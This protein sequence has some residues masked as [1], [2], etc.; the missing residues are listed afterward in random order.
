M[1]QT[2]AEKVYIRNCFAAIPGSALEVCFHLRP[3][4][5]LLPFCGAKRD[6]GRMVGNPEVMAKSPQRTKYSLVFIE[7]KQ[8]PKRPLNAF[9]SKP[10]FTTFPN[11][12]KVCPYKL[13]KTIGSTDSTLDSQPSLCPRRPADATSRNKAPGLRAIVRGDH[14]PRRGPAPEH[15]CSPRAEPWKAGERSIW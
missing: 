2:L 11:G 13:I 7:A 15:K 1:Q 4:E 14:F 9:T 12:F 6:S 3:A 8:T 10:G 5:G